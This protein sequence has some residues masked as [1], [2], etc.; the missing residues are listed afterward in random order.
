MENS[1]RFF[2]SKADMRSIAVNAGII[3]GTDSP[4]K[5]LLI[6]REDACA[7]YHENTHYGVNT[8]Y[9]KNIFLQLFVAHDHIRLTVHES[10]AIAT[11]KQK[12]EEQKKDRDPFSFLNDENKADRLFRNVRTTKSITFPFKFIERLVYNFDSFIT[13]DTTM[14]KSRS[15]ET[16]G[17][18]KTPTFKC[19]E[20]GTRDACFDYT[21]AEIREGFLDYVKV[22]INI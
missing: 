2:E 15:N 1:Y 14:K 4:K 11:L 19:E 8:D 3:E 6:N 9:H 20:H 13:N 17:T 18:E 5:L 21:E 12:E 10:T 22:N 7:I 16:I